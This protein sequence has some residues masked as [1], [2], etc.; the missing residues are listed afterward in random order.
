MIRLK[1]FE[2]ESV[3][4]KLLLW[5]ISCQLRQQLNSLDFDLLYAW[6]KFFLCRFSV[7]I[8]RKTFCRL[9]SVLFYF[10][11]L[12]V[13][14]QF[15]SAATTLKILLNF[16]SNPKQQIISF[17]ERVSTLE[18]ITEWSWLCRRRVFHC[19]YLLSIDFKL[20]FIPS[21]CLF[22]RYREQKSM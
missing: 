9:P 17:C 7:F 21:F 8:R 18:Y 3:P 15:L 2:R 20:F 16:S 22:R 10:V 11:F 4:W 6:A 1:L 12:W 14:S 13:L 19:C 5:R